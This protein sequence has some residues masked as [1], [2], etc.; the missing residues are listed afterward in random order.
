MKVWN[1]LFAFFI[2]SKVCKNMNNDQ[3]K[4]LVGKIDID[5]D[6]KISE[7]DLNTALGNA[8]HDNFL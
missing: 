7:S 6:G 2:K 3:I 8:N 1:E 4:E 5:S